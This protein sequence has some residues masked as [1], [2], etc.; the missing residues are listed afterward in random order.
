M[1]DRVFDKPIK[2]QFSFSAEVAMVFD[3]MLNRSVPYYQDVLK[4]VV[5]ISQEFLK[6]NSLIFDIGC[7][8]GS[9]MIELSKKTNHKIEC[10]G[11]DTSMY[12][13]EKARSKAQAF[14][15]ENMR[16][17]CQ[18]VFEVDMKGADLI[19]SNYTL[20]FIRPLLREKLIKKIYNSLNDGQIF[21]FSEKVISENKLL[22]KIYID[23]YYEFK[24][25][26]GYSEY[27][28]SQKREALEN[29][30]VPYSVEENLKMIKDSGFKSCDI[31][32]KWY[33]FAT[34]IAIK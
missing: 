32:F 14:G 3:D 18:D 13:I 31:I 25:T 10:C 34:F 5:D 1:E 11:I 2:E 30:L 26:Q 27:E 24:K 20:Q 22:N 21:I 33:N 9:T 17:L 19:I 7:S 29:V 6:E 12:M 28:I 8:T 15:I 23:K 16:F 4:L